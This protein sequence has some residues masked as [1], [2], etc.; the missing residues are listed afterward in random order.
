LCE[1]LGLALNRDLSFQ[2]L[3]SSVLQQESLEE[4]RCRQIFLQSYPGYL[5]YG[6]APICA[7]Q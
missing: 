5:G 3:Y 2:K 1:R 4:W 6:R 7:Q